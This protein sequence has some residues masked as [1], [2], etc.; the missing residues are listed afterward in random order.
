[1][2]KKEKLNRSNLDNVKE[3]DDNSP[4]TEYKKI[5]ERIEKMPNFHFILKI[6]TQ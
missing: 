5:S 6:A 4:E 3:F 1:M 2:E